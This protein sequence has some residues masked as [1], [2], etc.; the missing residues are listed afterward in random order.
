VQLQAGHQ[1]SCKPGINAALQVL[2]TLTAHEP[3]VVVADQV[4]ALLVVCTIEEGGRAGSFVGRRKRGLWA[5]R[6][7]VCWGSFPC[8][9]H[10]P[11]LGS[12]PG[13]R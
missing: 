4:H 7:E 1:C 8:R 10:D 3:V 11:S 2:C 13:V 12:Y 5:E 6:G 9:R